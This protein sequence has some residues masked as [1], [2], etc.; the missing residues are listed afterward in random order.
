M[1]NL[2]RLIGTFRASPVPVWTFSQDAVVSTRCDGAARPGPRPVAKPRTPGPGSAWGEP[3]R[4]G[5][6][7]PAVVRAVMMSIGRARWVE[8]GGPGAVDGLRLVGVEFD[9]TLH[10]D[11]REDVGEVGVE[12]ANLQLAPFA[13][14][15]H[16]LWA[17]PTTPTIQLPSR[18][19]RR[20]N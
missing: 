4:S 7:S 9:L 19:D 20:R 10:A 8:G 12:T 1:T 17:L 14:R 11:D 2:Y 3:P 13:P 15:A 5:G 6:G 16:C 18:E